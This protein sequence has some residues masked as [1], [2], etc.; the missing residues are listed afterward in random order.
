MLHQKRIVC[1]NCLD[2][3]NCELR[4]D[5]AEDLLP[6]G[7][8]TTKNTMTSTP[9]FNRSDATSLHQPSL[10]IHLSTVLGILLIF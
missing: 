10:S 1:P 8:G 7:T 5:S 4:N 2:L 9:T 3:E 6:T